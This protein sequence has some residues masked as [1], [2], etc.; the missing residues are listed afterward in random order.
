M[1]RFHI[2]G[3]SEA[4]YEAIVSWFAERDAAF[5]LMRRYLFG[6]DLNKHRS[7][8]ELWTYDISVLGDNVALEFF[9][10]FDNVKRGYCFTFGEQK[11]DAGYFYAPYVPLLSPPGSTGAINV[12]VP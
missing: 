6:W 8:G 2:E 7:D 1:E 9:L 11:V 5:T 12:R 10:A 3:I 4:D